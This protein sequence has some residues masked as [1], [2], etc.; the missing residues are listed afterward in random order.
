MN[1]LF[2]ILNKLFMGL[3][4][5][6]MVFFLHNQKYLL[7]LCRKIQFMHTEMAQKNIHSFC[8]FNFQNLEVS[9]I[10]ITHSTGE[11]H[12][13]LISTGVLQYAPTHTHTHTH[14][15]I[16]LISRPPSE[17][18]QRYTNYWISQTNQL[19]SQTKAGIAAYRFQQL[20]GH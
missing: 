12:S 8:F 3:N 14:T 1:K 13:P 18:A 11:S 9:C 17:K 4:K 7:L 20:S 16:L 5:L 10:F 15:H 19:Y 6:F 2:M